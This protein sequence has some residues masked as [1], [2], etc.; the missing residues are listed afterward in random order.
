MKAF[1]LWMTMI[2][3]GIS[4]AYLSVRATEADPFIT[5]ELPTLPE[6]APHYIIQSVVRLKFSIGDTLLGGGGSAVILGRERISDNMYRYYILTAHH[7]VNNSYQYSVEVSQWAGSH[8]K[9]DIVKNLKLDTYLM[10]PSSDWAL[11][12]F[13]IED[14]HVWPVVQLATKAEFLSLRTLDTI[15]G[16]GCDSVHGPLSRVGN[17]GLGGIH[18]PPNPL[19]K[20]AFRNNPGAFFRPYMNV[21]FGASGGGVFNKDGKLIGIFNGILDGDFQPA[22]HMVAAL[23]THIVLDILKMTGGDELL[24]EDK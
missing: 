23:K 9:A 21:W 13:E 19:S 7:V 17:F 22:T 24:I 6:H 18:T 8:A 16:V 12:S 2:S 1:I 11:V 15:Y 20:F 3:L 4:T 14:T 5:R 10:I